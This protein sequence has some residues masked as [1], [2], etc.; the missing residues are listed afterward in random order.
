MPRIAFLRQILE[1]CGDRV[2]EP[3]R[4]VG[5][6]FQAEA[7]AGYAYLDYLGFRQPRTLTV[8]VPA[9][10]HY[11]VDIIDTSN[12]TIDHD[13]RPRAGTFGVD[14]PG[15]PYMAV[16]LTRIEQPQVEQRTHVTD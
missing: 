3:T 2:F 13:T 4:L 14:L 15:R 8:T 1:E 7:G 11:T 9:D 10:A 16:R 6:V 5:D 12:M